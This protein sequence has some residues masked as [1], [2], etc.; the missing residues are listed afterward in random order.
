ARRPFSPGHLLDAGD[1][2]VQT[3]LVLAAASRLLGTVVPEPALHGLEPLGAEQRLQDALA[4][5]AACPEERLEV[6]LGQHH[7]LAELLAVETEQPADEV[8]H[9]VDARRTRNPLAID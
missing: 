5:L 1:E 8:A 9:L 6:A 4:I 3:L 2:P 7:D